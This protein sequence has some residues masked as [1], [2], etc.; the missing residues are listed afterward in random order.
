MGQRLLIPATAPA[1]YTLS[2]YAP[3]HAKAAKHAVSTVSE[4]SRDT[5]SQRSAA[6]AT[7]A[8]GGKLVTQS[9]A[10]GSVQLLGP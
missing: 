3:K 1:H 2:G 10:Q 7:H 5:E 9:A 4:T 8:G 6:P